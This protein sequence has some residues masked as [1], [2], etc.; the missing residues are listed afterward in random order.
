MAH[1]F[2]GVKEM[3]LAGFAEKFEAAGFV[4]LVFD[5]RFWGES[6]GEPRNQVFALEMVEDYRNAIT[7][8]SHRPEVDCNRIGIWGTS[9]SGGLCL[10]VGTHDKRVKAVVAQ[11]P[12]TLNAE[13][14]R[15][16]APD[17]WD[18]AGKSLIGDRIYRYETGSL[19]HLKVVS[20]KGEPS[21]FPD[22]VAFEWY[23]EFKEFAPNWTNKITVESLEKVREFDPVSLIHLMAPTALLLIAGEHDNLI[24]INT[25]KETYDRALEPKSLSIFPITHFVPY[26]DPWL[27][28]FAGLATDWYQKHL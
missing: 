8:L 23:M 17:Q 24:P 10:Y 11:V 21:V 9:Y 20:P 14:R 25:V 15:A 3:G 6:E 28:K 5:Y 22:D 18:L 4:T 26:K 27:S 12:S 13:S 19:N 2:A 16:R 7:W 1:G